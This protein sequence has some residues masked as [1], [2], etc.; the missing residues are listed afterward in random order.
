MNHHETI[1]RSR[2]LIVSADTHYKM[3]A[4]WLHGGTLRFLSKS[5]IE[6]SQM[7]NTNVDVAIISD[8][9]VAF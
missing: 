8:K 2:T 1:C 9:V 4:V 7:S 5:A 3:G 6:R